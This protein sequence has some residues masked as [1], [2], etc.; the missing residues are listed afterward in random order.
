[1]STSVGYFATIGGVP[2]GSSVELYDCETLVKTAVIN[3]P[4][5]VYVKCLK[6]GSSNNGILAMGTSDNRIKLYTCPKGNLT[7]EF[8]VPGN[9]QL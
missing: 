6:I 3:L 5:G 1:M 8:I 7:K 9:Q 4:N 2:A